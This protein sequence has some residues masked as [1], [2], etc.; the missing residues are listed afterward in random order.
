MIVGRVRLVQRAER[1]PTGEELEF[2]ESLPAAEAVAGGKAVSALRLI[3]IEQA[4]RQDETFQ[5]PSR[6]A[7]QLGRRML[8]DRGGVVIEVVPAAPAHALVEQAGIVLQM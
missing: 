6:G 5:R 7:V 1:N 4:A 8:E 2:G 3:I